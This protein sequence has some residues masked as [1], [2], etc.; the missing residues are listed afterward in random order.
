MPQQSASARS[1]PSDLQQ[2]LQ[3]DHDDDG[4][5]V[6]VRIGC[7]DR[8]QQKAGGATGGGISSVL[9]VAGGVQR[10]ASDPHMRYSYGGGGT[11]STSGG[12]LGVQRTASEPYM[13]APP[14]LLPGGRGQVVP[15]PS[16]LRASRLS[17]GGAG[18]GS[19]GG[20]K[21]ARVRFSLPGDVPLVA[22]DDGPPSAGL[23]AVFP[24]HR[25]Q[26]P[27]DLRELTRQ[28]GSSGGGGGGGDG[29]ASFAYDEAASVPA[30]GASGGQASFG[31]MVRDQG[32]DT[33]F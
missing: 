16:A 28:A 17:E 30:S 22:E 24:G 32:S 9:R 31:R 4:V 10:T 12:A 21:A 33:L 29:K 19:G 27:A 11:S 8:E 5:Y 3:P 1:R 2:Q 18:G 7:L 13:M 6:S 14:L 20:A 26:D 23:Q 25:I 15:L